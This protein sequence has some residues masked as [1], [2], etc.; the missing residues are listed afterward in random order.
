[1]AESEAIGRDP[2]KR[3]IRAKSSLAIHH[4][5][6]EKFILAAPCL[7]ASCSSDTNNSFNTNYTLAF[8]QLFSRLDSLTTASPPRPPFHTSQARQQS[9]RANPAQPS[10]A[11]PAS[12]V[13]PEGSSRLNQ[14]LSSLNPPRSPSA[15]CYRGEKKRPRSMQPT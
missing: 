11:S 5:T 10:P 1:M 8:F 12:P 4:W 7:S 3:R 13:Q 2:I 14:E 15:V 6:V 9:K